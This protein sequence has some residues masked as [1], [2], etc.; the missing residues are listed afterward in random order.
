[1]SQLSAR[2]A[3]VTGASSGIGEAVARRFA[4]AGANVV[5]AAR[6]A[7]RL[8]ALATELKGVGGDVLP[9]VT[10]V[11]REEDVER[12]F[13]ETIAR[14]GRVDLLVNNAGI[15]DLTAI[16]EMSL[17]RWREV[18]DIN[19][20]SIFLCSRAAFRLMKARQRGR[21]INV[22]SISALTP[23]QN[24]AAYTSTKFALDGFTRALALDGR[25]HGITV[26]VIHPG[27]TITELAPGM[28][29]NGPSKSMAAEDVA[30][31]VLCMAGMPDTVNVLETVM[32]P[33]GQPFLGRG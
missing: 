31:M 11:T 18:M 4:A 12:L 21:I 8:D 25:E 32:L 15:A 23:R 26:G 29:K 6:R 27:S 20:T 17:A 3:I 9:F 10:D 30:D 33:I 7:E 2:T 13:A 24:G 19:L 22:G 14:L 16:D 28:G 5:I 1:M